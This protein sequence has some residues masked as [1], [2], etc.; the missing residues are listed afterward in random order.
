VGVRY[1][2]VV[3]WW[4]LGGG[5]ERTGKECAWNRWMEWVAWRGRGEVRKDT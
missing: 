5:V 3:G 1:V 2:A 4:G